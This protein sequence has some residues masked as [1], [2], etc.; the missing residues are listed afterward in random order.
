MSKKLTKAEQETWDILNTPPPKPPE[1]VILPL[2]RKYMPKMIANELVGVQPMTGPT[3]SIFKLKVKND[4][5]KKK[6]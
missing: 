6:L 3:E 5:S 4:A 2:I 1:A